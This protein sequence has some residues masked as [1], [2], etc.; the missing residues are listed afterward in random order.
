M[1]TILE[2]YRRTRKIPDLFWNLYV[3]RPVA[4]VL[5]A[6]VKNT[7]I[8]PNQITLISFVLA[9]VAAAMIAL[10]PG[11]WG[12]LAAVVTYELSYVLDCADGMLARWRG[13]QSPEGHLFDFLMDEL[14]AFVI[15]GVVSVRL[16]LGSSDDRFLLLGI[17]GLVCLAS[18]IAMTTFLRRPEI[19]GPPPPASQPPA[20][21]LVKRALRL[22]ERTAKFLIHYPSYILYVAI[23]GRIEIY[24][25]VYIAV[26]ALY[27]L[28]CL[29]SITLRFGR[30]RRSAS[31]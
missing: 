18:G 6:A 2:V 30:D 19:A 24:F 3:C 15:L 12:L 21:S 29:A 17:G 25:Y 4:A 20:A 23:A 14:K 10:L 26:N 28:R 1:G 11:Y 8:T 16:Y 31:A 9:L 27:V 7:R 22:A 13:I 5:V